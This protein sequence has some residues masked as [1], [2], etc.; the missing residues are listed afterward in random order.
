M[1][2]ERMVEPNLAPDDKEEERVEKS[3]RPT[4]FSEY[5]GQEKI[6][7]IVILVNLYSEIMQIFI[8]Y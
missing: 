7:Y 8:F 1:A 2:I 3:L 5:I 4:T 6:L